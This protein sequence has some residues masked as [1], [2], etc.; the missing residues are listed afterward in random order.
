[1]GKIKYGICEWSLPWKGHQFA[2]DFAKEL[3]FDGMMVDLGFYEHDLP[4]GKKRMQDAYMNASAKYGIDLPSMCVTTVNDEYT[5]NSTPG[6]RDFYLAC[7]ALRTAVDA[8]AAMGIKVLMPP[9]FYQNVIRNEEDLKHAAMA[10]REVCPYAAEKGI[11]FASEN[12]L[13]REEWLRFREYAGNPDN[14]KIFF[15]TQNYWKHKGYNVAGMYNDLKEFI[16]PQI[17]VKDGKGIISSALLG[18]GD[19]HFFETAE[20]IKKSGFEGWIILEGYYDRSLLAQQDHDTWRLIEKD[21]E[22]AK[23]VFG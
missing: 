17:H 18:E 13:T 16:V 19:S 5:M 6:L 8:A 22:T 9:H 21:L 23:K 11:T 2:F 20:E 7:N 10:Y 4:M 1:M 14:L 12:A 15:D 3:G